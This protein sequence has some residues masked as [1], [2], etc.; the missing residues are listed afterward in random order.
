M[1]WKGEWRVRSSSLSAGVV[2]EV[3]AVAVHLLL[4]LVALFLCCV[5]MWDRAPGRTGLP[6]ELCMCYVSLV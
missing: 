2:A 5:T 6:N 3:S 4:I 1:G